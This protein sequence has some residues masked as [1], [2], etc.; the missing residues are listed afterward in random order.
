M[1]IRKGLIYLL[2]KK[3]KVMKFK[4]DYEKKLYGGE[5]LRM[6]P[7]HFRSSRLFYLL[8]ALKDVKGKVLDVGC[9]QGD[10]SEAVKHYYPD[11]SL[12]GVDISRGAIYNAKKRVKGVKFVVSD[13]QNLSFPDSSFDAVIC[14]DVIEHVDRPQKALFEIARVLKKGGL[15][16]IFLPTEGNL[17][18][19][20]GLLIKMGWQGKKLHGGHLHHF[21]PNY[22]IN[23]LRN[24]GFKIEKLYWGDHFVHQISEITYFSLLLITKRNAY[25]TVEGYLSKAKPGIKMLVLKFIKNT[26]ALISYIETRLLS[27][28]PAL[29]FHATCVKI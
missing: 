24:A 6:T 7:F 28:I 2:W 27:P 3:S 23:M 21:S 5:V 13:V 8:K 16:Q 15:L 14:L 1:F 4:F 25:N 18:T 19:L 20:E 12:T 22:A 17:F 29:G 26:A 9:G 10:V 11:L